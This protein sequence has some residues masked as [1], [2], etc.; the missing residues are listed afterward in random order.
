MHDVRY[1]ADHLPGPSGRRRF[2]RPPGLLREPIG[3]LPLPLPLH[4]IGLGTFPLLHLLGRIRFLPR[5][6]R[7]FDI[8]LS[9]PGEQCPVLLR[10][11]PHHPISRFLLN[12]RTLLAS[13]PLTLGPSPR[14]LRLG[15]SPTYDL[16]DIRKSFTSSIGTVQLVDPDQFKL[17]RGNR[18]TEFH[19]T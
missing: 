6:H 19:R 17:L 10:E 2:P 13:F 14:L 12:P 15:F 4:L 8:R 1:L 18:L 7:V 11:L 16:P 3:R 9:I 5:P